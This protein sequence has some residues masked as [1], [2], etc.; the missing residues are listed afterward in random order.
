MLATTGGTGARNLLLF[1][2]DHVKM[3]PI[4]V[5]RLPKIMSGR[6][7]PPSVFPM[8]HPTNNPGIAAGVNTGRIVSAVLPQ[9]GSA[10]LQKPVMHRQQSVRHRWQ[11]SWLPVPGK[12]LCYLSFSLFSS[13][14]VLFYEWKVTNTRFIFAQQWVRRPWLHG[15]LTNAAEGIYSKY[16]TLRRK[17]AKPL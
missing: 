1:L 3:A 6:I 12:A 10:P 9:N 4:S 11:Q 17:S 7:A 14:L 16:M 8:R 5:A 13:P 15:H 2:K